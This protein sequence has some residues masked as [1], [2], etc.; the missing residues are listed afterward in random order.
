M[1][2][3]RFGENVAL[4]VDSVTEKRKDLPWEERKHEA[5]EHIKTFS[6]DSLLVKSADLV[7]NVSEII[8]DYKKG[9]V[10][11][12]SRFNAPKE[13]VLWHYQAAMKAVLDAWGEIPFAEDL[14]TL[15]GGLNEIERGIGAGL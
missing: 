12:F 15:I 6:H 11:I 1:I 13:K 10:A 9:G 14:R 3:E 2:A 7:S 8:D 4:L 5:L